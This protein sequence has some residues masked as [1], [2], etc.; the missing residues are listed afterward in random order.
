[1]RVHWVSAALLSSALV[2]GC[3]DRGSQTTD[4]TQ[5]N[6]APAASGPAE[7]TDGR[8]KS[9][10]SPDR[11]T[12]VRPSDARTDARARSENRRESARSVDRAP[13]SA[14]TEAFRELTIPAGMALP[15][16][17][18][19][20][21]SSETAQVETPVRARLRNAVLVNGATAIPAGTVFNGTVTEAAEA[22]RVKGRARLAF[23]FDDAEV[24]GVRER[25]RTNPVVF[26]GE[27]TKGEDATKIGAGAGIGAAIGGLIG[28]GKGAAK[29]AAIG[30]AAGTG[31]VLATRGKEVTLAEGADISTTL[32]DSVTVRVPAR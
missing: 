20:P 22:G 2:V 30:G 18:M 9:Q 8:G 4:N 10:V 24:R 3:G 13:S 23:R 16:E 6:A 26:E 21:L 27:A 31:A 32:A 15:L 25:L 12:A 11:D 28:G 19:T 17:L 29:G 14:P 7:Q 5:P 1:M